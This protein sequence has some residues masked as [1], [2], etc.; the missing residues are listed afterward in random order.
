MSERNITTTPSTSRSISV[1][2]LGVLAVVLLQVSENAI[3]ETDGEFPTVS[4][5]DPYLEMHTG[6]GRGYPVFHVVD[7]GEDVA[8]LLRRTDWFKIRAA[9]GS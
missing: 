9:D 8:I 1:I 5:A 7:R 2:V 3:A 4:V 6:P